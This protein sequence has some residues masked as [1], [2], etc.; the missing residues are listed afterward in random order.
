MKKEEPK[1]ERYLQKI[2]TGRKISFDLPNNT[3]P[4]LPIIGSRGRCALCSTSKTE[5]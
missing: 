4:H 1:D 2:Q 3:E 5:H